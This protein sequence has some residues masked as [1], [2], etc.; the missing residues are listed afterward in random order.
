MKLIYLISRVFWSSRPFFNFLA[1]CAGHQFVHLSNED[2][3]I[4]KHEN[5]KQMVPETLVSQIVDFCQYIVP[6]KDVD[7][8][9]QKIANRMISKICSRH[10]ERLRK[11]EKNAKKIRLQP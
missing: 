6:V 8:E 11:M 5:S 10:S 4:V 7:V 3:T 2:T 1:H 9:P